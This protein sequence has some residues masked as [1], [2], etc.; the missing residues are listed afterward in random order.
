MRSSFVV[1]ALLA[2]A[3]PTFAQAQDTTAEPAAPPISNE[4][5]RGLALGTGVRASAVSA[6]AVAY[7]PA[8]SVAYAGCE[9]S[10]LWARRS[11][12]WE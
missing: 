4:T 6:A 12:G 7:S 9:P 11:G 2:L 10:A 3:L 5:T 1:A 8:D